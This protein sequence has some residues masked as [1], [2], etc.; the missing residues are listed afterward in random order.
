MCA[1]LVIIFAHVFVKLPEFGPPLC[2]TD[3]ANIDFPQLTHFSNKQIN[4]STVPVLLS[5]ILFFYFSSSY[6]QNKKKKPVHRPKPATSW[7]QP[8]P[9]VRRKLTFL[10]ASAAKPLFVALLDAMADFPPLTN[11]KKNPAFPENYTRDV[12][13]DSSNSR[14]RTEPRVGRVRLC[15]PC[16]PLLGPS[17]HTV[18]GMEVFC[19]LKG[20]A[21]LEG[22]TKGVAECACMNGRKLI[23]G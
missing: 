13:R 7:L 17:V 2:P 6:R 18:R 16:L 21:S 3:L 4:K 11:K 19:L 5:L 15:L 23:A 20:C 14:F 10:C 1:S 9:P 8:Q 22:S 12:L